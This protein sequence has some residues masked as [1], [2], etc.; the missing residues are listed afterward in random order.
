MCMCLY[1]VEQSVLDYPLKCCFVGYILVIT[2]VY[3]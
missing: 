1:V 3:S 2:K